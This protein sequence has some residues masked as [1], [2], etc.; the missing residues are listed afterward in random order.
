V[1]FTDDEEKPNQ[2]YVDIPIC[3]QEL[4]FGKIGQF[5]KHSFICGVTEPVGIP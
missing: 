4:R 1:N 3:I 5:E 2:Q